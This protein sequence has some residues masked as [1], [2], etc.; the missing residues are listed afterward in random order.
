MTNDTI[1]ILGCA[2][3]LISPI[4]TIYVQKYITEKTRYKAI[5]PDKRNAVDGLWEG[6]FTQ[7][8]ND[9]EISPELT[10]D[11]SVAHTG[12]ITGTAKFTYNAKLVRVKIKGGFYNEYFLKMN[13]WNPNK[14]I[15]QFGAFI[16]EIDYFNNQIKG[17]FTGYGPESKMV[18]AGPTQLKKVV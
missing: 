11:I 2:A 18:I 13:Y 3:T 7:T 14:H 9:K 8:L 17:Y 16:F 12:A 1:A 4:I 5:E 15:T 10:L 6:H